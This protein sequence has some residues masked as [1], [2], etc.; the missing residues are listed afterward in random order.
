LRDALW[1]LGAVVLLSPTV[2]P[3]Y[4]LWVLPFAAARCSP[5]WL[6]LCGTVTLAYLGVDGDV[7]WPVR[8]VEYLPPL[9]VM[10]VGGWRARRRKTRDGTPSASIAT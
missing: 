2:H 6:L 5:G 9:T 1:V 8:C 3:W 10:L 4:L 7:P